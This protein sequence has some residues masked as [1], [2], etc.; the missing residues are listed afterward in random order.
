MQSSDS[1]PVPGAP[2]T[3]CAGVSVSHPPPEDHGLFNT[4]IQTR[5]NFQPV[6]ILPKNQLP[7]DGERGAD[8]G[9]TDP[10]GNT[11]KH[12]DSPPVY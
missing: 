2:R 10:G 12:G 3:N 1:R 5:G 4:H 7:A 11:G 8:L 9:V 6:L